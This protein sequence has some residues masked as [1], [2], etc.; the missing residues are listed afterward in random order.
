M[1]RLVFLVFA[2]F[3]AAC[4]GNDNGNGGV[5]TTQVSTP[6]NTNCLNGTA[7]CNN[8][9][10]SQYQGWMAYPGLANSAYDYTA[11]FNQY[12]FCNCPGGYM[13]T[14]NGTYGLGCVNAQLLQPYSG[15]FLYWQWGY[16]SS[17]APQTTINF[18]QFSNIPGGSNSSQCSRTLT[19]SC[20]LDQGNTCG[21]GATCRQ[22]LQGSNLGVCMSY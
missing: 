6:L 3:L 11:Y 20:L 18:P 9:I 16:S 13:P 10:Y 12:G 2:L 19:Q 8:T 21:T 1:K 15:Y 22:V 7:Y 17:P 14:Y 5:T 4:Q